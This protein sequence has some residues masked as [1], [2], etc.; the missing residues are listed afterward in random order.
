[1]Q[2]TM[3]DANGADLISAPVGPNDR[4][5]FMLKVPVVLYRVTGLVQQ[6]HRRQAE[7]KRLRKVVGS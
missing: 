2:R 6:N 7:A 3:F 1:M 4:I 5:T